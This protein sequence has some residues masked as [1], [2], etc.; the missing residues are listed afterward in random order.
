[1]IEILQQYGLSE[2]EANIYI[3]GLSL[4]S[5]PS[6]TIAR[7]TQENRITVYSILKEL[8]KKWFFSI[9]TRDGVKYF[10]PIS[11]DVLL[12]KME[13]KYLDFKE[14]VPLLLSVV[15]SNMNKPKLT[16]Y[17]GIEWIKNLYNEILHSKKPLYAFLSDAKID[18]ILEKYLNTTFINTRKNH[19]IHASVIVSPNKDTD[20]YRN[21]IWDNDPL[22][23]IKIA[24]MSLSEL[25]WEIILF[26]SKYIACALYST[27]EMIWFLVESEQFYKSLHLLF[28]FVWNS[29][30]WKNE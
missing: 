29:I 4:W 21:I 10:S 7:H 19:N 28:N 9:I 23:T 26:D 12:K 13:Q 3:T 17:E 22:T 24:P 6:S 25:Q 14:N 18:P 30:P 5:V 20:N 2:R 15:E 1:M 11:P 16:Y 8:V 27:K